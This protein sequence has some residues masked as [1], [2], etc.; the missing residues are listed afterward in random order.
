M[1]SKS[2]YIHLCRAPIYRL[3]RNSHLAVHAVVVLPFVV[4]RA[5]E[6]PLRH[7]AERVGV[8]IDRAV[9]VGL[10]TP[11][12][13]SYLGG[14]RRTAHHTP[15]STPASTPSSTQRPMS[16]LRC[17]PAA[18]PDHFLSHHSNHLCLSSVSFI[19]EV[20]VERGLVLRTTHL[21]ASNQQA[22]HLAR[23]G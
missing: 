17:Q 4:G 19:D 23:R 16:V 12:I 18:H 9:S 6:N 21:L 11:T 13:G 14:H 2:T 10:E 3:F 1:Y 15:A 5:R 8:V 22:R 7:L 20:L